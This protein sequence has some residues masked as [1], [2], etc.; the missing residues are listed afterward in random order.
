MVRVQLSPHRMLRRICPYQAAVPLPCHDRWLTIETFGKALPK[1]ATV[2]C[3]WRSMAPSEE[4][5][6]RRGLK[7]IQSLWN[8]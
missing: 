7:I 2:T 3:S 5:V 6:Y 4:H 1:V 8:R